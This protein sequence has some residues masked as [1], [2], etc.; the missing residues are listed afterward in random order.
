M[1]GA[2][3]RAAVLDSI[4]AIMYIRSFRS[5][6]H[7]G[8]DLDPLGLQGHKQHP[9]FDPRFFGFTDADLDRPIFIDNVL[10]LESASQ[11]AATLSRAVEL[12]SALQDGP[13]KP[14]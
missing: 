11:H 8:A 2:S 14:R 6:G 13:A 10:G 12:V 5:R 3:V 4:R 7:L 9:E 1:D